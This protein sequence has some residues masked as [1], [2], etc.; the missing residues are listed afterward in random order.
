MV[1]GR[2]RLS[3]HFHRQKAACKRWCEF[4]GPPEKPGRKR[5]ADETLAVPVGKRLD[6][7]KCPPILRS[8]DALWGYVRRGVLRAIESLGVA[9]ASRS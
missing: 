6:T 1:H 2:E 7:D 3:E 5:K 9:T 4:V 8:I